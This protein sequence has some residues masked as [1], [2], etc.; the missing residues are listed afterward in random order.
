MYISLYIYI[1]IHTRIQQKE[2]VQ[3]EHKHLCRAR[4]P[5]RKQTWLS[6]SGSAP[7]RRSVVALR[8]EAA[9]LLGAPVRHVLVANMFV[10]ANMLVFG[11]HARIRN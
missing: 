11:R 9:Q 3:L 7:C 6:V 4:T 1:Y 8:G 2:F 5:L 10:V